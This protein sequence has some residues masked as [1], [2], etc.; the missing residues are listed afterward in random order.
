MTDT[1]RSMIV[2]F[3]TSSDVKLRQYQH[4]F[5]QLGHQVV[6]ASTVLG[7]VAEPQADPDLRDAEQALVSHPLRQVARFVERAGT[8]PYVIEDTMLVIDALSRRQRDP[9]GLPGA[10]TKSW[11]RNLGSEGLLSLLEGRER[12]GAMYVCQLGAY[13]GKGQ[14]V[15]KKSVLMGTIS[16]ARRSSEAA[17]RDVP[18]SN[19]H[20]F[21]D[22]FM[23][24]GRQST[25]AE[26]EGPAFASV[27]YRG[28]CARSLMDELGKLRYEQQRQLVLELGR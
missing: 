10:D 24:D 5:A 16:P 27:D 19:P 17:L 9:L 26:M 13:L 1:G 2:Y 12:R 15:F 25:L 21:H 4:I 28:A 7:S 6:R 3:A 23:P 20:F 14:Y 18:V 11:W 8:L 22:I